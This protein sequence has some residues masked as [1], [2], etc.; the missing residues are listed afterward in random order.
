MASAHLPAQGEGAGGLVVSSIAQ[1][2]TD[3]TKSADVPTRFNPGMFSK[4]GGCPVKFEYQVGRTGPSGPIGDLLL[5][6]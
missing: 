5:H 4:I 2:A 1:K 3:Q 6:L